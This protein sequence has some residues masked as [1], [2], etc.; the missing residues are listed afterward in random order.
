MAKKPP[1]GP[2]MPRLTVIKWL[3]QQAQVNRELESILVDVTRQTLR[4]RLMVRKLKW[5]IKRRPYKMQFRRDA[6]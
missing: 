4:Y 2:M 6:T 1:L 3:A 5:K